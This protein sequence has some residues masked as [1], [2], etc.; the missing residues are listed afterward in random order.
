M[1]LDF[2]N[3][4][5]ISNT[6][7]ILANPGTGGGTVPPGATAG[8]PGKGTPAPTPGGPAVQQQGRGKST[9][10]L[11]DQG[12][13]AGAPGAGGGTYNEGER[14]AHANDMPQADLTFSNVAKALGFGF[15]LMTPAGLPMLGLKMLLHQVI[16]GIFGNP[17]PSFTNTAQPGKANDPAAR[18]AFDAA[19]SKTGYSSTGGMMGAGLSSGMGGNTGAGG[20]GGGV[21]AGGNYGAGP[22]GA[23]GGGYGHTSGSYAMAEGGTVP[24]SDDDPAKNLRAGFSVDAGPG[25]VGPPAS[26]RKT[27]T[28]NLPNLH[29][30]ANTRF[31]DTLAA[32]HEGGAMPGRSG[33]Y[34]WRGTPAPGRG[35]IGP[36]D[37]KNK[38]FAKGGVVDPKS[39]PDSGRDSETIHARPGEFVMRREAS[40]HYDPAVLAAIN[41]PSMAQHLDQVVKGALAAKWALESGLDEISPMLAH[42]AK[43]GGHVR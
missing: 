43:M 11:V 6:Q 38:G 17:I 10:S 13:E 21:G 15:G 40:V 33:S 42:L 18:A 28:D 32:L 19:A 30:D 2:D 14:I 25:N 36:S 20:V 34:A 39:V 8:A 37:G 24:N 4:R 7:T 16:P 22:R 5:N 12:R 23:H 26:V 27:L 9:S 41:D 31:L 1:A 35:E 3:L 29:T